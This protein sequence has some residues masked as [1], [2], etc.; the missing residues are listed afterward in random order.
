M[1]ASRL[2]DFITMCS[3]ISI[4]R[5]AFLF[6]AL[7]FLSSDP[8]MASGL[9]VT[10]NTAKGVSVEGGHFRLS[11][12]SQGA[13][14]SVELFDGTQWGNLWK[15]RGGPDVRI[16]AGG[17]DLSTGNQWHEDSRE[18]RP[19]C[20]EYR[21]SVPF[22]SRDGL[23]SDWLLEL[24]FEIFQEGAIFIDVIV[25]YKGKS[26][27]K[28]ETIAIE[29]PLPES[30]SFAKFSDTQPAKSTPAFKPLR[31][32][33]GM[34]EE[35]GFANEVEVL[36]EDSLSPN[37]VVGQ[38]T[39]S[40]G[41]V[42]WSF[43]GPES[44]V[45]GGPLWGYRFHNRI[46]MGISRPPLSSDQ[47]RCWGARIFHWVNFMD[48]DTWHPSPEEIAKMKKR[49][50]THLILHHEWMRYRGSNGYPPADYTRLRDETALRLAVM[51]AHAQ[52]IKVGLYIRGTEPY[53]LDASIFKN[54]D[55]YDGIY[56]DWHG[57]Q[58]CSDHE[59]DG[60]AAAGLGDQHYSSGGTFIPAHDYFLFGRKL[61]N[62]VGPNGFLMGHAGSFNSGIL[63]NMNFDG[64]VA[65]ETTSERE[66]FQS[67]DAAVALGMMTSA[68]TMP[69]PEE[70]GVFSQPEG[71]AKMAVWGMMPHLI[72]GLE[73]RRTGTVFP[74]DPDASV[75]TAIFRYWNLLKP[76]DFTDVEV[77]NHPASPVRGI[78]SSDK[79]IFALGYRD[80]KSTDVLLLVANLGEGIRSAEIELL[81]DA[82][83]EISSGRKMFSIS[84]ED[85]SV[86]FVES[87]QNRRFTVKLE[88]Y[89]IAAFLLKHR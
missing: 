44:S 4:K 55:L 40:P 39:V 63:A 56:V 28:L 41:R 32:A 43:S 69:W 37:G 51:A 7:F 79:A 3:R 70:A 33:L 31:F 77:I 10:T 67:R 65:G 1:R 68:I 76:F 45:K 38:Q 6:V 24:G 30:G 60:G 25:S 83:P 23:S 86:A 29:F 17:Q 53:A 78:L 34:H 85:G 75:N 87:L 35:A 59:S 46:A 15:G 58:G 42:V 12:P 9:V 54:T 19:D 22:I 84:P 8:V 11:F 13:L 5:I 49:G 81:T 73:N 14:E 36:I 89:Q 66:L 71:A 61:R 52:G 82:F 64:Y 57:A 27:E 80:R 88:Q 47:A 21:M 26:P 20:V 18:V 74:R 16:I 72:L 62:T 48:L 2:V 50:A